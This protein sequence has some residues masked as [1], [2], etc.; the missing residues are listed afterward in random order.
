MG[1]YFTLMEWQAY[2]LFSFPVSNQKIT[3]PVL[4]KVIYLYSNSEAWY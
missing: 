4:E 2:N 1:D 3:E